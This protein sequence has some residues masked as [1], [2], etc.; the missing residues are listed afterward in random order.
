MHHGTL[1]VWSLGWL[2]AAGADGDTRRFAIAKVSGAAFTSLSWILFNPRDL[3]C[4][5]NFGLGDC[6]SC[7]SYGSSA[8]RE[9]VVSVVELLQDCLDDM[10]LGSIR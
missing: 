7:L 1:L 10:Q 4:R 6:V 5:T 3:A 8:W 9:S 2:E